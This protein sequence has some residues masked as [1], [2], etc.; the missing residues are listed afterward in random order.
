MAKTDRDYDKRMVAAGMADT[1][2]PKHMPPPAV[3]ALSPSTRPVPMHDL[4][5][6]A[7]AGRAVRTAALVLLTAAALA[8][9]AGPGGPGTPG[10]PN[11]EVRAQ[12][13]DEFL[14]E[15]RKTALAAG[16]RKETLDRA[17]AGLSPDE[18]VLSLMD[19]QP[20]HV[21]PIWDY[22]A[23]SVSDK[24]IAEG[25][26]RLREHRAALARVEAEYGVP[27]RVVVA[28]WGIETYY[29]RIKGNFNIVQALATQAWRGRRKDWARGELLEALRILD[30]GDIAPQALVGSWAGAFGH[31][32]FMPSVYRS[33]AIDGNGDGKRDILDTLPDAFASTGNLLKHYDWRRGEPWGF[34]VVLPAGFP[35][36]QAELSVRKPLAD[37]QALGVRHID[38]RALVGG[39]LPATAEGSVI[40]PAGHKGPAFLVLDNF[41]SILR[42]NYATAYALGVAL[43]SDRIAGGRPVIGAWPTD[44]QALASADLQEI[45][46]RLTAIG[47][48]AGKADGVPGPK[49]RDAVRCYQKQLGV[50]ADGYP[51]VELLNRLRGTAPG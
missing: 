40:L 27:A 29:G 32:Q 44:T 47:C 20:E 8:G 26:T 35:W 3:R 17:F 25:K 49:T 36:D 39:A 50:P 23:T 12:S 6:P 38:G 41:R 31:T 46:Q 30:A 43:L 21:R 42:Y 4:R 48:D 13:F 22:L 2:C 18:R 28:I 9:C 7:R 45:Q 14:D 1:N 15:Y 19:D 16:I 24:R 11:P 37:W 34:E 5:K 10:R 51:T 33:H